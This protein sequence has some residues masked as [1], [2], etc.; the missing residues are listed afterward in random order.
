MR[1]CQLTKRFVFHRLRPAWN[2]SE[3]KKIELKI[4][5]RTNETDAINL[6]EICV[7]WMS[8]LMSDMSW[9]VNGVSWRSCT[10]LYTQSENK[11]NNAS[12]IICGLDTV[13]FLIHYIHTNR[14]VLIN[15]INFNY[16]STYKILNWNSTAESASI[17]WSNY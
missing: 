17:V 12:Y 11:W 8:V 5:S 6:M 13:I 4:T 7:C 9:K 2:D 15:F 14:C 10:I 3:K 1:H 16:L